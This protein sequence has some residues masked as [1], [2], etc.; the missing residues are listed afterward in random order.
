MRFIGRIVEHC[1]IHY[2]LKPL[3]Y[4]HVL[5]DEHFGNFK[6][7]TKTHSGIIPVDLEKNWKKP[8]ENRGG[9]NELSADTMDR[10]MER[11]GFVCSMQRMRKGLSELSTID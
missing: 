4:R 8:V 10:R 3:K 6:F 5:L 11:E 9:G 2:N 1:K 7:Q